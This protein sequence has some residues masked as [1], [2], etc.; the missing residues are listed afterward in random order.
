MNN[1]SLRTRLLLSFLL[2]IVAL[3]TLGAFFGY[4]I[5]RCNVIKRAQ[6]HVKNDLKS[7]RAAYEED[8]GR[9]GKSFDL[10][11]FI[12]NPAQ[13]KSQLGL[14][15]LFV[16]DRSNKD[17][18]KSGIVRRAFLGNGNGGTRVADSTE[19]QA[20][21]DNI[22]RQARIELR[23]TPM[24][25]PTRRTVLAS[26]LV[27]EY[28]QPFFD[29]D[30]TVARV[31]YGGKII[32]RYFGLIDRIHDQ[33]YESKLYHSKPV[34]TV[35]IFMDDVRIATNVLD[36]EG[37]RAIGTRVSAQVY[38]NVLK[39][40]NSWL[41]RAFVVTDWYLTA[42]EPIRDV[43]GNIAGIF[44]V[45][46]LEQPFTDMIR[47]TLMWY[48]I[49]IGIAAVFA[50]GLAFVLAGGIARPLTRIVTATETIAAGD[51]THRVSP[52]TQI[53]EVNSL[54][55]SFNVMAEKLHQRDLSL[56]EKNEELAVLNARYLDLVG[57][58]SH[59]LKGI[60]SSTMLN[61]CTVRDGHLGDILPQQKKALDSVVRNLD[62]FDHTVNNF[63]NLS[64]VEK[65]EMT[66]SR[67]QVPLREDIVDV[68]V[69][70]Y[71][72]QAHEKEIRIENHVP[73]S[74]NVNVDASLMLMVTNN[75][76][77]NAIK[78]GH[79]QGSVCIRLSETG[80]GAVVEVFNTG[81]PLTAEEMQK[82]FKRFSRLEAS[83]EAKKT[84]GT[85]LGL[86]LS[87]ETVER[88]GG[89]LWCEPR[90]NG[91]AFIFTIPKCETETF[92]TASEIKEYNYA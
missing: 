51:L 28:A 31:M 24:A 54:A 7:A 29:H 27:M 14:D 56:R 33:V 20:M 78:Y 22:F 17:S 69:D 25:L 72:R 34:G 89:T 64:R 66:L 90:E 82:L 3:G 74:Y 71:Q 88:H 67:T 23:N 9:M 76:I 75:L 45:G 30:G 1:R 48:L 32:N 85:G 55:R 41:D 43:N 8:I 15:Y 81:R 18:V 50:G 63:L 2:V 47:S 79:P 62:Y 39:K 59:E 80:T 73:L 49:I 4:N 84:R 77:G 12:N 83:P 26:A 46:I 87:K 16:V 35:T 68:S 36:R 10:I 91:N 11:S 37:A 53:R 13:I 21:G 44:Y 58:V 5:I 57:M 86:F 65:Q 40:G 70:A 92:T 6:N 38:D 42:Y 19:L 60:L 52:A 61:A